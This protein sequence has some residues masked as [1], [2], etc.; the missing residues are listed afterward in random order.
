MVTAMMSLC[1]SGQSTWHFEFENGLPVT[2]V[3]QTEPGRTYNLR[4]ADTLQSWTPVPGFPAVATGPSMAHPFVAGPMGFFQITEVAAPA[5]GWQR[6]EVPSLPSG[7]SFNFSAVSALNADQLWI[8]GGIAPGGDSCVLRS[9]DGGATWSQSYRAGGVG[10]FGDLQMATPDIGFVAGV[11]LHRTADGGV[12]WEFDQGNLPDPPGTWHNVGPEGYVYGM[13]VVDADHVWTAGYDGAIAGVLYHRVPERPQPD[14]ANPN[15]NT[16]WWLEWAVNNRG[17]YGVSAVNPTTAWAVGY[18]GFIWKTIDGQSWVPQNSGTGVALQDVDAVDAGTA[19]AVGDGGTILK[20]S[21]GGTT[22]VPQT[23]GTTENLVRIAAINP[24]VAWAVGGGGVILHT[25][26]GGATWT[27]Q[28]SGTPAMLRGVTAVDDV[29]AWVVGDGNTLLRTTDGGRGQW[30]APVVTGVSPNVVGVANWLEKTVTITGTGFRGGAVG[31]TFGTTA[32]GNVTWLDE[33]TLLAVARSEWAGTVD[34]T[35]TNEDGQ[36]GT[37]PRSMTFVPQ[38]MITRYGPLHGPVAGG[39]DIVVD[40]FNLQTVARAEFLDGAGGRESLGV[41]VLDSTRV[42]VSVP[43]STTRASGP[44]SLVLGTLQDQSAFAQ[45]FALDPAGGPVFAVSS[46][47]P[48]W[49]VRLTTVT[50]TGIGF[51]PT[52]TLELC[53]R[54]VPIVSRSDTQLV[55]TVSGDPGLCPLFVMN[56]ESDAIYVD[57]GF[58]LISEPVPMVSSVTPDSAP[59]AG[60][61][62]VTLTGTGFLPTDTVTFDGYAADIVSRTPTSMVVVVPP[63]APGPVSVIVMS[64]GLERSAGILTGGFRYR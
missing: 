12:T 23:S 4:Q 17:M 13:A 60:G 9:T 7:S 40:G 35:V 44:V 45:F 30:P 5:G 28:Y 51:S 52:A 11:G 41:R 21:D 29:T 58:L 55:G 61:E 54:N 46:V 25:R 62:S 59:A 20:T 31:V 39:Y 24:S 3:W 2:L 14:P 6:V 36:W 47:T 42:V 32:A 57:R 38:P 26:D 50:V 1:A 33:S 27:R 19:W 63:H 43:E 64:N 8:C 37:L 34:V 49:G 15:A 53:G 10:F 48:E 18:A 16:P 56:N 22:W